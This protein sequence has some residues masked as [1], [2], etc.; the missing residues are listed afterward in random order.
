[1]LWVA[2]QPAAN[3][4]EYDKIAGVNQ[5]RLYYD[6]PD[7][8]EFDAQ[9]CQQVRLPD[10]RLAVILDHSYFYPT[11]GGQEHDTG[12]LGPARVLDVF[13]HKAD[14]IHGPTIHVVDRELPLGPVHGSIDRDRRRR[15]MQHHTAQHLLTQC[16]QRLTG[17]DTVSANI[18]GD[19][20]ST[21]DLNGPEPSRAA[22]DQAEALANQAIYADQP[23]KT[24]YVSARQAGE[25]PLRKAPAV[26]ENI[27][28]IEIDGFDYSACGGTHCRHTGM[29]GVIKIV[30]VEK[31]KDKTRIHFV[32]GE[33]AF[34]L[35]R[36]S[37]DSVTT[38]ATQMSIHPNDL[39]S[40]VERQGEQLRAAQKELQTLRQKLIP[41]EAQEL[42][43]QARPQAG[44]RLVQAA[45]DG[46]PPGELRLLANELKA[47]PGVVSILAAYD[48]AKVSLVVASG[49][50]SRVDAQAL[51][52]RLLA[53]L[54]GRGGGDRSLAQG[55]G[56]AAVEQWETFI[57]PIFL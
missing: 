51:L 43:H 31:L 3:S 37:F 11:S 54:N 36:A 35:F 27:R 32:A 53:P 1:L 7:T 12:S 55:G 21:L 20:P 8:L 28:I 48:G 38:L 26:S 46:R 44:V 39:V 41:L 6:D 9:V 56:P 29:I 2:L 17:L 52:R 49:P 22:L 4:Y 47:Q 33:R 57:N 18:N 5:Q 25:L 40:S 42:L 13:K 16:L 50:D 24:Y 15:H 14:E 10:G 30:R 19:T 23:V 34:A 45:F